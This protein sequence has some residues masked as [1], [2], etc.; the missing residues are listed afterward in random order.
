MAM[1]GRSMVQALQF[2]S[3]QR[4]CCTFDE[5][6]KYRLQSFEDLLHAQQMTMRASQV[7]EQHGLNSSRQLA[8]QQ[9]S[10]PS[11]KRGIED[12]MDEDEEMDDFAMD[13]GR[14]ENRSAFA[15]FIQ[16]DPDVEMIGRKGTGL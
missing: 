12:T 8:G 16:G 14:Y 2:V 11:R 9:E 4:F 5:D 1:F 13:M 15:P 7:Q 6:T 10:A 3:A